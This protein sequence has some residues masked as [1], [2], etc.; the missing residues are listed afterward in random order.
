MRRLLVLLR[1]LPSDAYSRR[2]DPTD[3][4]WGVVEELLAQQIEMQSIIAAERKIKEPRQVP[5][6]GSLGKRTSAPSPVNTS[7]GL[8][9]ATLA[10]AMWAERNG[11]A[12]GVARQFLDPQ[13]PEK[14][15]HLPGGRH[16]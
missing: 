1:S 5:R 15:K 9:Q 13:G 6:P 16:A 14:V 12:G 7:Q 10:M 3:I 4:Y 8:A 2:E 11:G